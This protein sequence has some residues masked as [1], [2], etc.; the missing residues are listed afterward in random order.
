MM[1]LKIGELA[2]SAGL[3]VRTLHH[4]DTIGLLS[5]SARSGSGFRLYDKT[6]VVRLHR[7]QAL[8]QLGCALADIVAFLAQPGASPSEIIAQQIDVLDEQMQRAKT[9][10]GRLFRLQAQLLQEKDTGLTDWLNILELMTL[11]EKHF[12]KDEIETLR[13]NKAVGALDVQW[14]QLIP[15]AQDLIDRRIP[16][17]SKQAQELAWRWMRLVRS[18]TGNNA[19]LAMK[20][21]TM[22]RDASKAHVFNGISSELIEYVSQSFAHARATIFAKYLS[23]DEL[24]IVRARQAARRSDWPPLI[25]A[26]RQQIERGA[27]P[28]EPAVQVLAHRWQSLF[29]ASYSGDDPALEKKIRAAFQQEPYLL[30]SVGID[31]PLIAYMR[32]AIE[33]GQFAKPK[34]VARNTET[35]IEITEQKLEDAR[36]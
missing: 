31:A 19:S 5:P 18:A 4:Y 32:Q 22:H 36:L 8:K 28:G 35:Q 24:A 30:I 6:D 13:A 23:G 16:S 34:Q 15:L 7:I 3:T 27:T 9:L 11:Y 12:T 2:K 14:R 29:R 10:R 1:L 20:F 33:H 21:R 26:I 25:E 17:D